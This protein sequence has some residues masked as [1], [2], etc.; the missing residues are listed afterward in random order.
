M[1]VRL[2]QY[3]FEPTGVRNADGEQVY[4]REFIQVV[5]VIGINRDHCNRQIADLKEWGKE[6]AG[7]EYEEV[8]TK[9]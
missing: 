3:G 9:N 1:V 7:Y 4:T 5:D 8:S 2:R 6:V